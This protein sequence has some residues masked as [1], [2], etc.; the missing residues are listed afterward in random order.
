[1]KKADLLLKTL[2]VI[3][4]LGINIMSIPLIFAAPYGSSASEIRRHI[5]SYGN[6]QSQEG[7]QLAEAKRKAHNMLY[8]L[9]KDGL[10]DEDG[11][12][13]ML[14]KFG[15][16]MLKKL[17]RENSKLDVMPPKTYVAQKGIELKIVVFDIPEKQRRKRNWLRDVLVNLEYT[18]LQKSVWVGTDKIPKEFFDDL[19][20]LNLLRCVEI[21]SVTKTGSLRHV[22]PS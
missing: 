13:A 4:Q 22:I 1:M 8:R 15:R 7:D 19:V 16:S 18:M 17:R 10:I 3:G 21:L 5:A 12:R 9:R 14:N 2:E 20:R 11:P 6:S